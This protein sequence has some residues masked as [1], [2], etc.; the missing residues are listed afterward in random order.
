MRPAAPAL[1]T[2]SSHAESERR[3]HV[4][5]PFALLV[6]HHNDY[7]PL[8]ASP[9]H[10]PQPRPA[11]ILAG[12]DER[13][14]GNSIM[15]RGGRRDRYLAVA[16]PSRP[17]APRQKATVS[18][19][20]REH[21]TA[22]SQRLAR[23][24]AA[25]SRRR[26]RWRRWFSSRVRS[27][28]PSLRGTRSRLVARGDDFAPRTGSPRDAGGASTSRQDSSSR[29]PENPKIGSC[30]SASSSAPRLWRCARVG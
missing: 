22:A 24:T 4:H 3:L 6:V 16:L 15:G 29:T 25:G 28:Q 9:P 17:L 12:P 1:R 8:A 2:P 10:R 11:P 13:K 26:R 19:D 5:H 21:R 18:I 7:G 27:T 20:R 23:V 30:D 14:R